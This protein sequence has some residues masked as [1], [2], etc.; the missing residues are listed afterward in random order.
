MSVAK[1]SPAPPAPR[2]AAPPRKPRPPFRPVRFVLGA[3]ICF[4]VLAC[5][6]FNVLAWALVD[7]PLALA[8]S[9]GLGVPESVAAVLR[10]ALPAAAL[11]AAMVVFFLW[12]LR[13]VNG[14]YWAPV[15]IT[16][17]LAAAHFWYGVLES[18]TVP[19]W[20]ADLTGGLITS[21]PPTAFAI[22]AAIGA[23]LILGRVTYGKWINPASAY[24]SGISAGILIKSPELWPFV[25]CALIS[26][27]SKYALRLHGRHLWN[28]TNFGVTILLLLAPMHT[29]SLSVQYGNVIWANVIIWTLGGL[30]LWRIGKLHI[31]LTFAALY[32]PLALYRSWS[33]GNP[34]LTELAPLTGPMYQLFM[35][36]MITD[37]KTV[38]LKKWSQCL[39]AG[40]VAVAEA[41]FRLAPDGFRL[42]APGRGS[43]LLTIPPEWLFIP[44]DRL[45]YDAAFLA[46]F[47][48]GPAANVIEIWW[49]ARAARRKA[50]LAAAAAPAV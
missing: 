41:A 2:P 21:Y 28:P 49:N 45:S 50:R 37:P 23:E 4:G 29:A 18:H 1:A 33:T 7:G 8:A 48:V 27:A 16:F 3:V 9:A 30:I 42:P 35:C 24:V 20:L 47:T 19:A 15:L 11:I 6:Y 36:F 13:Q 31:P 17:I 44:A 43:F 5:Q 25:F 10:V 39:V 32:V 34:W 38:T 40:L 22:L 26:I 46:L 12:C 14:L